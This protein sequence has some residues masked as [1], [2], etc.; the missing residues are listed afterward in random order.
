VT[1]LA[2]RTAPDA[3][4]LLTLSRGTGY[5]V[6]SASDT[7]PGSVTSPSGVDPS[8]PA[9]GSAA[10]G[11]GTDAS[12]GVI[13]GAGVGAGAAG[14]G[15]SSP[16]AESK[17]A[18]GMWTSSAGPP[19]VRVVMCAESRGRESMSRARYNGCPIVGV[20]K[21]ALCSTHV[22]VLRLPACCTCVR[23]CVTS[24]CRPNSPTTALSPARLFP[25]PPSASRP[26]RGDPRRWHLLVGGVRLVLLGCVW[27][28]AASCGL[29]TNL[30]A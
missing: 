15:A 3:R 12:P 20:D 10:V 19:M 29:T 24:P 22:C 1:L 5:R 26:S 6:A 25:P 23:V 21:G 28:A 13:A 16:N 11:D 2:T 7:P 14:G 17:V 18:S 30:A 4:S 9:A 8:G 27:R